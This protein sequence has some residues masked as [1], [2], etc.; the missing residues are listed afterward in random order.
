MRKPFVVLFL[1]LASC[2]APPKDP[3]HPD[4]LHPAD[5]CIAAEERLLQLGCRDAKGR[6]V[7]GPN[8]R[9]EP[10]RTVCR[11]AVE[12]KVSL[13]PNCLAQITVCSEMQVCL[14]AR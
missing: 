7:G 8:R 2:P 12:N 14:E 13:R 1:L 5:T 10:F 11:I 9:G 6:L 3:A 4:D